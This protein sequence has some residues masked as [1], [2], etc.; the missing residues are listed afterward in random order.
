MHLDENMWRN[1]MAKIYVKPK[2][3]EIGLSI[4]YNFTSLFIKKTKLKKLIHSNMDL[5]KENASKSGQ[6]QI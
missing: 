6:K 1:E 2:V 5:F 3:D 4:P